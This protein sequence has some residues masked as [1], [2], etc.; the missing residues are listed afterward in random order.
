MKKKLMILG[1]SLLQLPAILK[2][3][4]MGIKVIAVDMDINAIGF[5]HADISLEISTIDIPKVVEAAKKYEI[6][7]ILTIASDMPM[8]TVAAVSEELNIVGITNETAINV[9]NKASM[10]AVLKQRN[11]PVPIFFKVITLDEFNLAVNNFTSKF[12]VKPADNSGSRGVLL[13]ED[14]TNDKFI[15]NAFEYSKKHSRSGEIILE[16]YMEGP[17][18]SVET[19]SFDGKT[20]IIA[21]TDKMTTG[22]P[23]F[24]EMGHSIP[25]QVSHENKLQIERVALAAIKAV[26][27]NNGPSHTEIILTKEGPK[28]VELGARLG[29]DNITTH[30]VPLATGIDMVEACIQIALGKNPAFDKSISMGSAIRYLNTPKGKIRTISGQQ[31]AMI[32]NGVKEIYINKTI[33]DTIQEIN[34]SLDRVGYVVAH[35]NDTLNAIKTCEEAIEKII[36]ELEY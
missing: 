15:N 10:R 27:I 35:S 5:K 23:K 2:A 32:M 1:A 34:S 9:T 19:L 24:V 31:E 16:E 28:V 13:V 4:E 33:G 20:H 6:D 18:V 8:R 29:G 17:E 21:V 25:S 14:I 26:G 36:I 12:I 30:L 11:V 22:A 7:G 3:K